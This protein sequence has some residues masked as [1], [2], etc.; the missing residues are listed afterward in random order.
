MNTLIIYA[1]YK[2]TSFNNTI[3]EILSETLHKNGHEVVL[4]DLYDIRF[5]PVL[6]KEDLRMIDQSIFPPDIMEEQRYISRAEL[7]FFIYPIWWSGM[8]AILKGYIERVFLNG[9]AF[10]FE[11][12]KPRPLLTGKKAILFNTTGS[13]IVFASE[14]EKKALNLITEKSI[15]NFCGLQVIGHHYFHAVSTV[16]PEV[17][18]NY[19]K[20]V[21]KIAESI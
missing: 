19:I 17:R 1:N 15:F 14:E 10:T 6:T 12:G 5:N 21:K 8:P 16:A 3:K 18:E 9:F 4:R 7:I 2:N 13:Q 20:Q 11:N